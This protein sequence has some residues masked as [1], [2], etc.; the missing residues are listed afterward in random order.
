MVSGVNGVTVQSVDRAS[1]M[2]KLLARSG[3][4]GVTDLASELGIHKSSAHRMLA[5]L[6][7]HG[8]VEQD[9]RTGKYRLGFGL[10]GLASA[11]TAEIDVVSNA[12]EA[13]QRLSQRTGE[14]VIL[15]T[16]VENEVVIVHQTSS[17]S[18]VLGV[19]WS[20][21][22]MPLHCTPGGKVLLAHL[23]EDERDRL[24]STPMQRFTVNTITD[25]DALRAE[26]ENVRAR[27]YAR[28]V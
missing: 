27:G 9:L 7:S 12:R 2:L 26:L 21:L 10:V 14:T 22:H 11:V 3:H 23:P 20:G 5:T 6:A 18:S 13:S 15:T 24:I 4:L 28:T 17:S 16:L 1:R 8:L 19:D 25:P